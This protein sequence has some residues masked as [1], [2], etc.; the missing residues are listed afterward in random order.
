MKISCNILALRY[1]D[2]LIKGLVS[3]LYHPIPTDKLPVD[4]FFKEITGPKQYIS[5]CRANYKIS[6]N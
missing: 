1:L 4:N 6:Y 5:S 2:I 3:N